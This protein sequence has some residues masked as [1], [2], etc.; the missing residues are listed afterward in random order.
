MVATRFA[1]AYN[2]CDNCNDCHKSKKYNH[3]FVVCANRNPLYGLRLRLMFAV[4]VLF[5]NTFFKF[6]YN[7]P[8][9]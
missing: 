7:M 8:N 2:G 9:G 1:I 3:L 4:A 5:V 6:V